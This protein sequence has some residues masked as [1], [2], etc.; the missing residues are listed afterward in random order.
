MTTTSIA[1]QLEILQ[2]LT[3][4]S[5]ISRFKIGLYTLLGGLLI[6]GFLTGKP[7]FYM[8]AAFVA[9]VVLSTWHTTPH[10]KNAAKAHKSG[11]I[12]RGKIDITVEQ[13]S[14]SQ[15]YYAIIEQWKFEFIPRDGRQE[16]AALM[17]NCIILTI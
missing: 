3:P 1:E 7:P 13:W 9:F 6:G 4:D 14:D 5:F 17:L 15:S 12:T 11:K 2:S 8:A 10:I 16:K